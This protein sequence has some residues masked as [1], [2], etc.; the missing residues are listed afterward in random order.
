MSEDEGYIEIDLVNKLQVREECFLSAFRQI[1]KFKLF[2][3][4]VHQEL[5]QLNSCSFKPVPK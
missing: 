2:T 1:P 3:D 4:Q 5:V